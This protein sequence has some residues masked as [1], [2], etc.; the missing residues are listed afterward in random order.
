MKYGV[1]HPLNVKIG[2]WE[3]VNGKILKMAKK[4]SY[5]ELMDLY[6][7]F[8]AFSLFTKKK[9]PDLVNIIRLFDLEAF[10]YAKILNSTFPRL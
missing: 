9:H 4:K 10:C 3:L 6:S 2:F 7:K 1:F 8:I 5:Q